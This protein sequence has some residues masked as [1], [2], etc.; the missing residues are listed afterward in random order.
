[1]SALMPE[2]LAAMSGFAARPSSLAM[3]RVHSKASA[4]VEALLICDVKAPSSETKYEQGATPVTFTR[5]AAS[6]AYQPD[7]TSAESAVGA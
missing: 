6:S 5:C 1:M 7:Q 4:A 2:P 3:R